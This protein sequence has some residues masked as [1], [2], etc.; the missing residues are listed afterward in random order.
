VQLSN[1]SEVDCIAEN[2]P[3]PPVKTREAIM[4]ANNED[5]FSIRE[6]HPQSFEEHSE[7][8]EATIILLIIKT[9]IIGLHIRR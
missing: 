9:P 3:T 6:T 1:N 8:N 5:M 7:N 4:T 2:C